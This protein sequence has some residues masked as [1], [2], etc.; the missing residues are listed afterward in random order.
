MLANPQATRSARLTVAA[1][2]TA[3]SLAACTQDSVTGSAVEPTKEAASSV[4]PT[5]TLSAA[6]RAAR[7][8]AAA[9]VAMWEDVAAAATTSDWRSP[10]LAQ[11]ATA[12]ALSTLSRALYSDYHQGLVT[13][14]EPRNDPSVS[15]MSPPDNPTTVLINDCGDSTDWLKYDAKTGQLADDEP[16]GRRAITAEV[17]LGDDGAWR[18]SRFAVEGLATC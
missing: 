18:V 12:D 9:Y 5:P 15:S 11:H 10:R 1:A 16:G 7:D 2:M 3:I 17:K 14:G 6:D 13:K 4:A 8:A